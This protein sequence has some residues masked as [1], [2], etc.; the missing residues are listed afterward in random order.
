ML[1]E[2][3]RDTFDK[4]MACIYMEQ[5]VEQIWPE[6]TVKEIISFSSHLLFDDLKPKKDYLRLASQTDRKLGVSRGSPNGRF[7]LEFIDLRPLHF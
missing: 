4:K 6:L 2:K 3:V 7:D 1:R 5:I